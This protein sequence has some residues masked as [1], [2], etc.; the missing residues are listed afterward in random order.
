MI[1]PDIVGGVAA[2][3]GTIC[4]VPQTVKAW[5]TKHT[6]DLSLVGYGITFCMLLLWLVY[7]LMIWSVPIIAGNALSIFLVSA[8]LLA[9]LIHG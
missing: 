6:K 9:K 4:W 8:I 3:L 7:G 2:T 1:H 5:R